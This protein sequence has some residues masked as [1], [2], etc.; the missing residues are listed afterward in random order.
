MT[1]SRSLVSRASDHSVDGDVA[2]LLDD[3]SVRIP[4]GDGPLEVLHGVSFRARRGKVLAI[5]GE[6]G[7][8]KSMAMMTA[9]RLLPWG[10]QTDGRVTVAGTDVLAASSADLRSLRASRIRLVFQDP[11][12]ALHPMRTIG[13]QLRDSAKRADSSLNKSDADE[14]A[15]DTMTK[16]G[17]P[18]AGSR[19]KIYP[20]QMS[21]GQLQRVVIACGLVAK[22]EI[23]LCDEPTTALDVTTQ[24]QVI[25]LFAELNETMGLTIVIATHDLDV[26]AGFADDLVV[27]YAGQVMEQ[28]PASELVNRPRHPYTWALLEAAPHHH[29]G[30]RLVPIPGRPPTAGKVPSG[31]AFADR[32]RFTEERCRRGR[33]EL[34]PVAADHSSACIRVTQP[35]SEDVP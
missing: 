21:G 28:G 10:S 23:L 7:S 17:I 26:V 22:P 19:L 25:D 24:A 14:L 30:D 9:M 3:V 12:S 34:W 1:P 8:G 18:D 32:C 16:V 2:L 27:M 6:S 29:R 15:V 4:T 33:M 35:T 11:W 13:A 5:A 20:H 31:C